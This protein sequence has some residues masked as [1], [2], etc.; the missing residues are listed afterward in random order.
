MKK[1][2]QKI[3]NEIRAVK[4]TRK[5]IDKRKKPKEIN[6]DYL[7]EFFADSFEVYLKG[8]EAGLEHMEFLFEACEGDYIGFDQYGGLNMWSGKEIKEDWEAV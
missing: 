1:F 8:M 4:V 6:S 2:R 3:P 7:V 5:M